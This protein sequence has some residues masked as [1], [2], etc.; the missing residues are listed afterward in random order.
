MKALIA[1]LLFA[2]LLTSAAD[3]ATFEFKPNDRV[4]FIGDAL[5][6]RDIQFN[7]LETMLTVRL[8]GTGVTF[9]NVGWSG[10]TVWGESR[11]VFGSQKDGYNALVRIIGE[12]KPTVAFLNYGM[13]ESF[14]GPEG[15]ARFEQQYNTLLDDL[16]KQAPGVRVILVSPIP[17]IEVDAPPAARDPKTTQNVKLY[18]DAVKALA[19]KRAARFIDL[20]KFGA[21]SRGRE[22][23]AYTTDGLHL[24]EGGYY[25]YANF[26]MKQLGFKET[27][28]GI[29]TRGD[30]YVPIASGM[31][32]HNS[33]V[34]LNRLI[35]E[36]NL[37]FFNRWRPQNETYLFLFRKHEQGKNAKDIPAFDP[38]IEAKEKEIGKFADELAKQLKL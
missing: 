38:V 22:G 34:G 13:N 7:Y 25:F 14:A 16:N 18:A 27:N 37:Q 32:Q 31:V 5:I 33:P 11:G 29:D 19:V 35:A 2:A 6:E 10:D 9:R 21:R 8:H 36:K 17:F 24:T 4:V 23:I 3:D 28:L 15:V 12:T 20:S 26:V 30:E 1:T